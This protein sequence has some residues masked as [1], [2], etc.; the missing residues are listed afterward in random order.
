[1]ALS[2]T[3]I[4]NRALY[5]VGEA[6]VSNVDTDDSIAAEVISDVWDSVRDSLVAQYPWNFAIA[7]ASIAVDATAPAWGY[8]KRYTLPSD[9]LSLLEIKNTPD[10]KI[11]SGYIL[12]DEGSPL[13]IRY[14][15]KVTTVGDFDT[16]FAEALA[17]ELAVQ[18]SER[19]TQSNTKKQILAAERDQVIKMAFAS[20]AI[21]D[22]PQD[23][24]DD[25]WLL[26]RENNISDDDIDYSAS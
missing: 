21:Q 15:K 6:R 5:K 4:A 11:E 10:Y 16:L 23:L 9:F 2:K 22:P 1:M 18:I 20:D 24:E 26:A 14:I 17:C 8:N 12:T 7:R 13:K 25:S 19:L 3:Q